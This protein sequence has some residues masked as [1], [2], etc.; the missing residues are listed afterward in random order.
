MMKKVI[1]IISI[2]I[3]VVISFIIFVLSRYFGEFIIEEGKNINL[4]DMNFVNEFN[5]EKLTHIRLVSEESEDSDR[6]AEIIYTFKDNKCISERV[7][8]IFKDEKLENEQY[9]KWNDIDM[10]N[11][12]INKNEV[13]FN[14]DGNIGKTKEEILE[15]KSLEYV[16]Y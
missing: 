5:N 4:N 12:V 7:K 16:E 2:I 6:K 9:E 8:F 14:S 11:L 10:V 3:I 15:N 13:C 1:I